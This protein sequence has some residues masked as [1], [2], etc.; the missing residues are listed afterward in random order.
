MGNVLYVCGGLESQKVEDEDVKVFSHPM[1]MLSGLTSDSVLALRVRAQ[2]QRHLSHA[3]P[4]RV[5]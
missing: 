2:F 4:K 5:G 3:A 1:W